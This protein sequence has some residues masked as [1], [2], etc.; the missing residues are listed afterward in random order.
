MNELNIW[1]MDGIIKGK[2]I[3]INVR[4]TENVLENGWNKKNAVLH[5]WIFNFLFSSMKTELAVVVVIFEC[6]WRFDPMR[7]VKWTSKLSIDDKTTVHR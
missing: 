4:G 2:I 7:I 6:R 1:V 3:F 5:H